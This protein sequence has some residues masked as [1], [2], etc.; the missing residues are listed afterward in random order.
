VTNF[1]RHL[2]VIKT[3]VEPALQIL[4]E[5]RQHVNWGQ[6]HVRIPMSPL[7]QI[8]DFRSVLRSRWKIWLLKFGWDFGTEISSGTESWN[9]FHLP[10]RS[11][12][13]LS[14]LRL[15]LQFQ[16]Y[17]YYKYAF[18]ANEFKIMPRKYG[19]FYSWK[20]LS[21]QH[22]YL[23]HTMGITLTYTV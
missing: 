15:V 19:I 22:K 18:T 20:A 8:R 5:F 17:A 2:C 4:C 3:D 13:I 12:W 14:A 9:A 23:I 21:W 10:W 7:R 16:C 11:I 6:K 1:V